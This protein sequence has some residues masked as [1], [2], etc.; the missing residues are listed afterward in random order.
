MSCAYFIY[1]KDIE[2]V[3]DFA[4]K[5][6]IQKDTREFCIHIMS[7]SVGWKPAFEAHSPYIKSF[8]TLRDLLLSGK[9]SFQ[10]RDDYE[11][12]YTP[13]E[14]IQFCIEQNKIGKSHLGDSKY[15]EHFPFY[16]DSEGYEFS[17][18]AFE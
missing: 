6:G 15:D 3:F 4:P 10:I 11:N 5:V 9:Y 8:R 14:F 16:D 13:L 17:E 18:R 12:V 7:T 1:T 2:M